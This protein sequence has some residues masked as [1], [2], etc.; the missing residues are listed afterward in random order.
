MGLSAVQLRACVPLLLAVAGD[1]MSDQ[2][3]RLIPH[4]DVTSNGESLVQIDCEIGP[5]D[6]RHIW[7]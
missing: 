6:S 5:P 7:R 4:H 3:V 1:Q 2:P